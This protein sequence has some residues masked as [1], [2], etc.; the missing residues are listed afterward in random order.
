MDI[1]VRG[2]ARYFLASVTPGG[3]VV[4]EERGG[5]G[6]G[7]GGDGERVGR[8]T[9][10]YATPVLITCAMRM[11]APVLVRVLVRKPGGG[12]RECCG[13]HEGGSWSAVAENGGG[14]A[15]EEDVAGARVFLEGDANYDFGEGVGSQAESGAKILHI[16]APARYNRLLLLLSARPVTHS[17]AHASHAR[18]TS[19]TAL[20]AV[21]SGSHRMVITKVT[22]AHR[23]QEME[24]PRE[25]TPA[26]WPAQGPLVLTVWMDALRLQV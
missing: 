7:E 6:M 8:V 19:A 24:F 17:P 26:D 20:D 4:D 22:A 21:G 10:S 11:H 5:R 23:S 2:L 9:L 15:G 16:R 13:D 18:P 14:G 3:S 25:L 12:G 1:R